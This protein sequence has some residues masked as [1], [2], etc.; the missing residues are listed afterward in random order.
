MTAS[1]INLIDDHSRDRVVALKII[2]NVDKYR[3]AAKLEIK[4]L[5]EILTKDPN[6]EQ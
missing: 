4:V 5:E 1:N 6:C 2:K 3:D